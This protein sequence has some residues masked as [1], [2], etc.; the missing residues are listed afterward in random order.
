MQATTVLASNPGFMEILHKKWGI[1]TIVLCK[2]A[3]DQPPG[4]PLAQRR[5]GNRS[6]TSCPTSLK[7]PAKY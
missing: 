1:K 6:F 5:R 7:A 2:A 4:L 3:R